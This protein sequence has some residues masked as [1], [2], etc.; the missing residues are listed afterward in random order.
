MME[1]TIRKEIE[2][3]ADEKYREF[4]SALC[5]GVTTIVGVRIPVLRKYAKQLIKK[6]TKE[7]LEQYLGY[8]GSYYEETM[9][10]GMLIGLSKTEWN[11]KK[12]WIQAFV[13]KIDNWAVCDIVCGGIKEAKKESMQAEIW[14]FLMPYV[15]ARKEF[16]IRFGVVMLL[17]HFINEAYIEAIL[18]EV[19]QVKC[20]EYYAQMAVAWL[21]SICYIKFPKETKQYLKSSRLEEFTYQK[22]IQKTIES[23]RITAEE[24]E[25]L[26][27]W[28]K[29]RT[30]IEVS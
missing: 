5:P 11:T 24:K 14:E 2:A 8:K 3:L 25:K 20:T 13:P 26:R 23:Y 21:L 6:M 22:A 1:E 15:H 4:H 17:S 10:Q 18:K 30:K 7:E 9:L 16:E 29:D 19:E 28:K 27:E 12:T